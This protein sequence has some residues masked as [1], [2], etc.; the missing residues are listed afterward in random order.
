MKTEY[1]LVVFAALLA[2]AALFNMEVSTPKNYLS[3][4]EEFKHTYGKAYA[5]DE[6]IYRFQVFTS[7]VEKI[8]RHNA[9]ATQTYTMEVNQFADMTSEEF[10]AKVLMMDLQDHLYPFPPTTSSKGANAPSSVDWRD[11]SVLNPIKNQGQCGSCWAF[12][13]TGTLESNLA[14]AKG[15][16]KSFSEQQL[17]DCCGDKGY[18][19]LGCNGAWPEW[20]FNY[21]N[22]AGIVL[23]SEYAYTGRKAACKATPTAQKY[24]NSA[25]PWVMVNQKDTE[26][27]KESIATSGPVS[28]CIDA[29]NWSFYKS[30]VFSNC[31]T[32]NLNHAVVAVGY[33]DN[34]VWIVRNSWGASWGDKGY[35]RL[36]A[37]NTCGIAEHAVVPNLI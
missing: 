22:N 25:K 32:T 18:Q 1:L 27:L 7:N 6:A 16:L 8:E 5:S 29:S 20:A 3:Q 33:E 24:L 28:I 31:G 21:I 13:T 14:I 9:D 19:C 15:S 10:I 34:G 12:S 23:E 2:G 30:G 36:A 26:T 35:I 11:K 37:G 17:V 4:F